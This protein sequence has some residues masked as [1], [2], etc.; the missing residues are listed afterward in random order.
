M[1]EPTLSVPDFSAILAS[2]IHDM[3]ISLSTICDLINQLSQSNADNAQLMQL[4]F[5]ANRMN[6][7]LMQLLALYRIEIEKFSLQID[8]HSS[9]EILKD[10]EAQQSSLLALNDIK[11]ELD[12]SDDFSCYCD[13]DLIG[14]AISS[15]L[16]NAQRYSQHKIILSAGETADG[17]AYFS[18]EDDGP[19][20]PDRLLNTKMIDFNTGNTGLGLYFVAII[21]NLHRHGDKSGYITTN[22]DSRLG[23]GKFTLYLP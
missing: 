9:L 12:N 14:N 18:I 2:S 22:N 5:E 1:P 23:G 20:F 6:N 11:L 3:K 4:E 10:I 8:E 19:G 17:F 16:N 7:S 13:A 21:A 15:I